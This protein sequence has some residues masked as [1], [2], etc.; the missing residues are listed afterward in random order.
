MRFWDTSA[1]VPL[2]LDEQHSE[3]CAQGLD[4]DPAMVVWWCTRV[5]CVSALTR[6]EREGTLTAEMMNSAL[7]A[8][9]EL[10]A[11]WSIVAPLDLIAQ[12][13]RRLLRVH[14]LRAA[15]AL[16]LASALSACAS[17]PQ[18]VP[19]V[20]LDEQLRAAAQ[21]EGCVVTPENL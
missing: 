16:Q 18:T 10:A 7:E 8:L 15:D 6:R 2:L 14:P 17:R 4:E 12:T 19:F 13:A 5:E 11:G 1:V 9:D 3:T 21:R 20:C